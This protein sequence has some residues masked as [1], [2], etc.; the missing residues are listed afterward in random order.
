MREQEQSTKGIKAMTRAQFHGVPY[1]RIL[2]LQSVLYRESRL[3]FPSKGHFHEEIG[4]FHQG[5]QG[6]GVAYHRIL[7][8]WPVD[9]V[10]TE[11]RGIKQYY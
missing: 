4:I 9:T 8:F 1:P 7:C 10:G 2:Y 5:H 11:F 3:C 6:F